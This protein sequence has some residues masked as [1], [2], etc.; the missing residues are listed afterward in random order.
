MKNMKKINLIIITL[1]AFTGM[2]AQ[3]Y[4]PVSSEYFAYS[5]G[6]KEVMK[7]SFDQVSIN[8]V[9]AALK[10]YLKNYKA[11]LDG[12]KGV[13]DEYTVTDVV[14]SDINQ[15][16]TTMA[17]KLT[18]LEGNATMYIHYLTNG[19]IVSQKNTPSEFEG[20][21]KLTEAI[22]NKAVFYA[23]DEVI[24]AQNNVLKEKQKE[25]K[26]L[27]KDEKNAHNSIGNAKKSI[28]DSE[29]A[30]TSLKGALSNQQA[31][32][33]T[34]TQQVGNKEAE[35][36]SVNVKTLEGEIKDIE[37]ENKSFDKEIVKAR[38]DIAKVNGEIA[39]E[40]TNLETLRK[41][42]E[43]QKNVLAVTADKKTLKEIQSLQKDETKIIGGIEELKG[44]NANTQA[45][46]NK[47]LG[48]IEANKV[49]IASIQSKISSHSEDALKDQLKILEKDL[50]DLQKEQ[51]KIEK[52]LE[53]ENSNITKE[54]ENIRQSEAEIEKLKAAQ[55]EKK[56]EIKTV[57]TEIKNT[58][59]T[60]G[61]FK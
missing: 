24:E 16:Q 7:A 29:V 30:I 23:Y 52:D 48:A 11:K 40:S 53:K 49:K 3:T 58:E 18:E 44:E 21:K 54:E 51:G 14:V 19:K 60:Q 31:L 34:K 4:T 8:Q 26:G 35:I 57:E 25:L 43:A 47:N 2:Q 5:T 33:A 61:K 42:I 36:A 6:E 50:K 17:I 1:L 12:V 46:I 45:S 38:E 13:G 9:E 28:K 55:V 56:S 41:G 10:D 27:E 15:N 37:K 20:Y 32:V 22:S 59:T 39:I